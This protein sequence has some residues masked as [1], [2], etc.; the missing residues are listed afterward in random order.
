M[1]LQKRFL[2][3]YSNVFGVISLILI[4]ISATLMAEKI[5]SSIEK[6]TSQAQQRILSA[7]EVVDKIMAERV[8]NS[9]H[10]LKERGLALGQPR[11]EGM[12]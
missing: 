11:Q 4:V 2:V 1:N 6:E 7:M 12:V 10:L 9:M 5:H 3:I 8:T